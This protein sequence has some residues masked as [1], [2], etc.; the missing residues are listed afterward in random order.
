MQCALKL[1]K[2]A[3]QDLPNIFPSLTLPRCNVVPIQQYMISWLWESVSLTIL[4][5][6]TSSVLCRWWAL[7]GFLSS[8]ASPRSRSY[9][10]TEL[11][12]SPYIVVSQKALCRAMLLTPYLPSVLLRHRLKTHTTVIH[13]LDKALAKLGVGQLTA[14]EVKSVSASLQYQPAVLDG[15]SGA[16]SFQGAPVSGYI[17]VQALHFLISFLHLFSWLNLTCGKELPAVI[18]VECLFFWSFKNQECYILDVLI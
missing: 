6:W 10:N 1:G 13:Q 11:T 3:S 8:T 17:R 2:R 5:A 7:W 4:W 9:S 12:F 14:Q 15:L 18:L 16:G